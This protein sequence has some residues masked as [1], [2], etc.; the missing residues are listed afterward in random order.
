L[1]PRKP[2]LIAVD[3]VDARVVV[4]AARTALGSPAQ[5]GISHWDAS[6]VFQE[7]AVADGVDGSPS[8]R[9]LLLLYA[10]DLAFRLRW[11]IRPALAEGYT[12]VAA[13]YIKTAI[14]F[15]RASGIPAGWLE[16]L[17]RFAPNAHE[18][19]FVETPPQ[20]LKPGVDGFIGFVCERLS[21]RPAGRTPRQIIDWM[22]GYFGMPAAERKSIIDKLVRYTGLDAH[23]LDETNLRWDVSHFTRQLL[24]DKH[25]TIGRYDG[26]LAGPADCCGE[27]RRA[28]R[29]H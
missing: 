21:G 8:P 6:G 9:T 3:G 22:G 19:Q 27:R 15:G 5:G 7:L 10:A 11:E 17:F 1:K 12:V 26:R 18:Q 20:R 29:R 24:R 13:P 16:N 25:Q 14:A 2:R 28:R 23:Y 4:A